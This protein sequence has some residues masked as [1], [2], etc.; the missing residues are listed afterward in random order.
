MV[1]L[2]VKVESMEH[3]KGV[4]VEVVD[5]LDRLEKMLVSK[6]GDLT[7]V[8]IFDHFFVVG[9]FRLVLGKKA[10]GY[11]LYMPYRGSWGYEQFVFL[12]KCF[13]DAP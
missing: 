10:F 9:P 13:C 6:C 3:D 5:K 8:D 12:K 4:L 1:K 2:K 11:G 7:L